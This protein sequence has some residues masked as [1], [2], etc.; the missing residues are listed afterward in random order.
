MSAVKLNPSVLHV[1]DHTIDPSVNVRNLGTIFDNSISMDTHINQVCRT[2]FCHIHN[3]RRISKYFSQES[4]K[5]LVHAFVTSRID[6]CNSLLYDLSKYHISK[7][8]TEQNPA[9]RLITNT[10]KYD[11]ITP[12]LYNFH[13]LPVFYRDLVI[14]RNTLFTDHYILFT[15]MD[16][17]CLLFIHGNHCY[18]HLYSVILLF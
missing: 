10:R 17:S 14:C 2:A 11:H 13:W 1:G 18:Y 12:G 3:I 4:L 9:A 5:T 7:L 6:Y 8:Q 16:V 15:T